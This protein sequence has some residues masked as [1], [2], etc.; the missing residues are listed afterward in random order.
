MA[1]TIK[2]VFESVTSDIVI[3]SAFVKRIHAFERSIVN[4]N[5]DNIEFFGG[6]LF[7][8]KPMR[9]RTTDRDRWFNE[10]VEVDDLALEDGIAKV[11]TIDPSWK[12]ANDVYNLCCVWAVSA[13]YN[14]P[15]LSAAEKKQGMIDCMLVLQYK[16]MGSLMAHYFK[17]P[18]DEEV[19]LKVYASLNYKYAIK[20]AGSIYNM[21]L[22][23][24]EDILS[25]NSIH[26]RAWTTLEGDVVYMV[27]DIQGRLR[28][29]VKGIWKVFDQMRQT[30]ARIGTDK[31][32]LEIDG[33]SVLLDKVKAQPTY[34]RYINEIVTDRKSFIKSDL[35]Q[36]I[37]NAMHTM[38]PKQLE[39]TL[40]WMS[41]NHRTK[42]GE[43]VELLLN[44]TMLYAFELIAQNRTIFA[45]SGAMAALLEKLRAMY[46][47]ARMSHPGLIKCR[48]LADRIV[49]KA[50]KSRND[51]VIS[52][53]RTG[54]Q[55]YI[56][57][58]ALTKGHY[59]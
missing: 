21:L 48:D 29:I 9:Y 11:P 15:H 46:R 8:V 34:I 2:Q 36:V 7:G 40:E 13:I 32:V 47:T 45:S 35:L 19:M 41:V 1:L 50:I 24:A 52:S 12:R 16:F 51:T 6:V 49:R 20:S 38:P 42:I 3:D 57:L 43:D 28:D 37:A 4:Y 17:Y 54:L 26:K 27:S 44:E 55:M 5:E 14:S 22:N 58:R 10:V 56:V 33:S 18:A 30:G 53:V 25:P 39:E 31:T 23:R 59:S